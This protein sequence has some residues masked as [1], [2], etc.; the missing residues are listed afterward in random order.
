MQPH[1]AKVVL[2]LLLLSLL[3][4]ACG[5]ALSGGGLTTPGPPTPHNPGDPNL[6]GGDG[7]V[8][9]LRGRVVFADTDLG[10]RSWV[11]FRDASVFTEDGDFGLDLVQGENEFA[12]RNLLG[13]YRSFLV[14]DGSTRHTLRFPPF[15]GW[16]REY[17]D[18]LLTFAS[19]GTVGRWPN[20]AEIPV[21]VESPREDPL[22]TG[23]GLQK[24]YEALE[25]WEAVLGGE[26]RFRETTNKKL[27][28]EQ[29]LV[30]YFATRAEVQE[31]SSVT[32]AIGV[33]SR[34]WYPSEGRIVAGQVFV[35][36]AYQDSLSLWLHEIGHCIGLGHSPDEG[37]VMHPILWERDGNLTEKEK[38]MAR[39]LYT[40]PMGTQ[41]FRTSKN[42]SRSLP[43][44]PNGVV[45][46]VIVAEAG[47]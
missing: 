15:E 21:W 6:T 16:S 40:I 37:D 20:G 27:A 13:E 10:M 47:M 39:L 41:G 17:F 7:R 22:I 31:Q 28:E 8:S 11:V 23:K 29:G 3:L 5:G 46:D 42:A 12:V 9:P 2:L 1:K 18:E 24:A 4:S 35:D 19:T 25:I 30:L 34:S 44:I 14:H 26:V 33:C 43:V 38:N 45:V 32:T 36:H